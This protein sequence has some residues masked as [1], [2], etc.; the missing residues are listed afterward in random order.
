MLALA[1]KRS[2]YAR[3]AGFVLTAMRAQRVL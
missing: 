2:L 1:R 3:G